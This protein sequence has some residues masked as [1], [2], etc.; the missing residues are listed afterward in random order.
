[1]IDPNGEKEKKNSVGSNKVPIKIL[2]IENW[3]FAREE[4]AAA[5]NSKFHLETFTGSF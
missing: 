5:G 3:A 4:W 1:M 2:G